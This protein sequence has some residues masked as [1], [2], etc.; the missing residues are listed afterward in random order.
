MISLKIKDISCFFSLD[1][2]NAY[3]FFNKRFFFLKIP[4]YFTFSCG[5]FAYMYVFVPCAFLVPKEAEREHWIPMEMELQMVMSCCVD[6][7]N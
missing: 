5:C 7:S 1:K 6:G 3:Y 2:S 4:F